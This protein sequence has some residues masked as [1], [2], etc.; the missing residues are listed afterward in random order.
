M[1]RF[2]RGV[3]RAL[4]ILLCTLLLV[5]G[6]P[7]FVLISVLVKLSSPGPV[8]FVQERVGLRQRVFRIYKFRTMTIGGGLFESAIHWTTQ[9]EDRITPI[10]RFL[11]DFGLDEL[12]QVFNILKG[13]MSIVGPRPPRPAQV[14][15]YDENQRQMFRVRPGVLSLAAVEGRRSIAM[16]KRIDLHVEYALNWSLSLD[17][18]IMWRSLFVVLGRQNA[19]EVIEG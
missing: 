2:Q 14:E 3:K 13:E 18:S 7:A 6:W 5:L 9:E 10:G 17:F 11:R 15:H 12:P 8:L 4:D 16:E 1:P 19:S